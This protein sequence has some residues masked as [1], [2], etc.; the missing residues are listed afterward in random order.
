LLGPILLKSKLLLRELCVHGLAWNDDIPDG[1][2]QD[3]VA[4][5]IERS[6]L[7][8]IRFERFGLPSEGDEARGTAEESCTGEVGV[9]TCGH[10]SVLK[11]CVPGCSGILFD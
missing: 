10:V 5:T 6:E 4:I 7:N 3:L 8:D 9:G 1:L 2:R 11:S